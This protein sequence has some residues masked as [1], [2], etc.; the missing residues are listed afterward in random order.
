MNVQCPKC[1]HYNRALNTCKAFPEKIPT[2]LP[3]GIIKHDKV[4]EGQT[5]EYVFEILDFYKRKEE[6]E[7]VK[8]EKALIMN[9]ERMKLLPKLLLDSIRYQN[10]QF[11][12]LRKIVF[13]LHLLKVPTPFHY[14]GL[15]YSS[16]IDITPNTFSV[17]N[18]FEKETKIFKTAMPI[19]LKERNANKNDYMVLTVYADGNYNY[20][21]SKRN[22]DNIENS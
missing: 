7:K 12:S 22:S 20:E 3:L 15:E 9:E 2:L 21:F 17:R 1:K 16:K 11:S 19:I 6:K 13:N 4:L 5:G 14:S 10:Y 18:G 8:K